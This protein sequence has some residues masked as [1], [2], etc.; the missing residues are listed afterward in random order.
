MSG[1]IKHDEDKMDLSLVP[2]IAMEEMA[3][4]FMLGEKKYGRYNYCKGMEA[5][6]LVA[7]TLRHIT[8]W[9]DGEDND[10]ESGNCHLGHALAGLAMILR[11]RELGSLIDNRYSSKVSRI[12][13]RPNIA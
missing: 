6:R 1:G 11:Q 3:K 8:A 4:A 12:E 2:K 7:S 9:N 13:T 5:S 10:P